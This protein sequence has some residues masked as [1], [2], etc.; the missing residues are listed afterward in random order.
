[1]ERI[2]TLQAFFVFVKQT[3]TR[4]EET[5][6]DIWYDAARGSPE[7]KEAVSWTSKIWQL[8]SSH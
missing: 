2:F 8:F 7:R 3:A 1:M 6:V 4:C 5:G